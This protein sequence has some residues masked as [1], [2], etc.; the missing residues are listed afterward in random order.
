M[1]RCRLAIASILSGFCRRN[2]QIAKLDAHPAD[3][4]LGSGVAL[5]EQHI[6]ITILILNIARV[7]R[8]RA[9]PSQRTRLP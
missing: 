2:R 9:S 4:A 5:G 6:V 7:E 3:S 8:A 1:W